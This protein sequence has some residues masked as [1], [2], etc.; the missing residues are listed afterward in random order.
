MNNTNR[1]YY[2]HCN[3]SFQP[4]SLVPQPSDKA[5]RFLQKVV[6]LDSVTLVALDSSHFPLRPDRKTPPHGRI[7]PGS[8]STMSPTATPCNEMICGLSIGPLWSYGPNK[9]DTTFLVE[10]LEST[11][12]PTAVHR[13]DDKLQMGVKHGWAMHNMQNW[14]TIIAT[15]SGRPLLL[16]GM[17]NPGTDQ[18]RARSPRTTSD[19][20]ERINRDT[21]E[22][23]IFQNHPY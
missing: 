12:F 22:S 3:C 8:R 15:A 20:S 17:Q 23:F 19:K 9:C 14:L 18:E 6:A 11:L 21:H 2:G 4:I 13:A 1:P 5:R 7:S 10:D 16:C